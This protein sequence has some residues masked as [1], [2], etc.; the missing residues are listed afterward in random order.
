LKVFRPI[1][2]VW[3]MSE[4][5]YEKKYVFCFLMY[6]FLHF[7]VNFECLSL[8]NL[9]QKLNPIAELFSEFFH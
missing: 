8:R 5:F 1:L 4:V 2:I 3:N 7:T 9:I 6:Y